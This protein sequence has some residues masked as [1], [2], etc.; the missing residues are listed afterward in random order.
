MNELTITVNGWAATD[1][2]QRVGPSGVRLTGF[3][4][5]STSRYFD[6]EKQ[7]WVDGRTEWFS[8]KVF[9]AA[10][11]T[12]A[13]SVKKGQPVT[14]TG[15]FRTS[16]WEADGG[17]R[18]DLVIDATSVGH[19]L[20]RG[21]AVFT[22]AIGDESLGEKH[23]PAEDGA[24][25]AEVEEGDAEVETADGAAE[26]DETPEAGGEVEADEAVALSA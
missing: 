5:A 7:E 9:R 14:V 13:E 12:V 4:L 23:K 2:V 6:R 11:I 24:A 19:D 15:R 20:T 3:R 21:T 10:A 26:I 25:E 17:T 18:V 8:V 16:E 1:P 22:R